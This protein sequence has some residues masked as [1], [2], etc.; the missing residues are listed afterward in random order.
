[1][2][3]VRNSG[4]GTYEMPRIPK[5]VALFLG[6]ALQ[7]MMDPS[8]I[9]YEKVNTFFLQRPALDLSD[10]PMFYTLSNSGQYFETEVNWLMD[11]LIAAVGDPAVESPRR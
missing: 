3:A 5:L 6:Q 8:H 7:V 9:L 11:I 2:N 1:M 10:I 4:D